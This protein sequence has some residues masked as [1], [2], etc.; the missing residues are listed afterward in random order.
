MGG[1]FVI[2]L[3]EAFE[4]A[5]LVGIVATYL[6]KIGASDHLYLVAWGSALGLLASI[7]M[8]VSLTWLSGPLADV[9]PDLVALV[10]MFGAVVLLTWHGWWMRQHARAIKGDLQRRIDAAHATQRLWIV[11]LIAFAGVFREGAETVL[12]L[13]GLV[14]Q[15]DTSVLGQL[16]GAILGLL[17]A[18]GLGWM[19]FAGGRAISLPRFFAITS[20]LVLLLAAGLFSGGVGRLEG[21]GVLP[22]SPEVWDTSRV[23]PDGSVAG[24]FLGGLLGYRARPTAFEITAY[25]LYLAVGGFIF[26]GRHAGGTTPPGVEVDGT[27]RRMAAARSDREQVHVNT[28]HVG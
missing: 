10:V 3:R 5:L 26:F 12:F 24:S 9:G 20:V 27:S 14:S 17:G 16:V 19:I 18:I 11:G 8:A 25:A 15:G 7:G 28:A 22:R 21:M 4:A 2:T 23:L 1:A 13:W 6:N